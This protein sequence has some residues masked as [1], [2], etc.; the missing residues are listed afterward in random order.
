MLENFTRKLAVLALS[1]GLGAMAG[2]AQADEP[3]KVGFVYIGPVGD[4]G[5]TYSHDL[6]RKAL[7]EALG[8]AVETVAVENVPEGPESQRVFEDLARRGNKLIFGTSFG[9]MDQM[10]AA[11]ERYPD[12][13][14]MN[15]TGFK[16]APN[17]GT[18]MIM[19]DEARY[20]EGMVAASSSQSDK[21]GFVAAFPIPEVL[22]YINSF[23]LGA[24][25][26]RPDATVRVVWTSTWYDPNVERQA[27][28]SLVAA[29]VDVLAQYQDTPSTGQVAQEAGI[30]WTGF[31]ADMSKFAP[32]AWLTGTVWNWGPIYIDTAK[33]VIDGTWKPDPVYGH[34]KD[35]TTGL[36]PY[37]EEVS[38]ETREKVEAK[39]KEIESG[40]FA[41]FTGPLKDQDGKEVLADGQ[42][43]TLKELLEI[44][45][46]V[47]G[48]LGSAHG[49]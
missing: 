40:A 37:G 33:A 49:K 27:A 22:R 32:K 38:A 45:Y 21:I 16:T 17:L 30:K 4:A 25:S 26:I 43:A 34:M 14:F 41:P 29:G 42:V 20:L 48:V 10:V 6:G 2:M 28:E 15:A 13:K 1:L 24:R 36:A 7:E 8:S 31:N 44:N 5:W 46:F 9:Y 39:R 12:V 35:G 47:D 11:A 23:T 18:Y 19:A 3:L